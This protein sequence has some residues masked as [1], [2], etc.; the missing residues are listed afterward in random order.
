MDELH[1]INFILVQ[2]FFTIR[3]LQYSG[4]FSIKNQFI[5]Y[6]FCLTNNIILI[7]SSRV[8]SFTYIRS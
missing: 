5:I 1:F 8:S 4:G 6:L 2:A 7:M 3:E